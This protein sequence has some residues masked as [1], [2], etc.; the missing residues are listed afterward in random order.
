VGVDTIEGPF[1]TLQ[2][3]GLGGGGDFYSPC[4]ARKESGPH[5]FCPT[6]HPLKWAGTYNTR[7]LIGPRAAVA[8][9]RRSMGDKVHYS[10]KDSNAPSKSFSALFKGSFSRQSPDRIYPEILGRISQISNLILSNSLRTGR[11]SD[12][13]G[14]R[15]EIREILS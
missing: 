5:I 2:R 15:T 13:P 14:S 11:D 7:E 8:N 3:G 12:L 9:Q 4:G 1:L 10:P 6:H